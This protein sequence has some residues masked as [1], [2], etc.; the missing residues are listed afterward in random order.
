[1]II[2]SRAEKELAAI[3]SREREKI[4]QKIDALADDPF[5]PGFKPL[6]GE[7]KNHFRVRIG[8][9]R[10]VYQVIKHLLVITVVHVGHRKDVYR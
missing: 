8:R 3:P 1:M 7:L 4:I 6:Q 10:V 5:P 9:Y 2:L